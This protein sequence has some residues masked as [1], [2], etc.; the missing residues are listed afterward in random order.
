[1]SSHSFTRALKRSALSLAVGLCFVGASIAAETGGLRV[2]ITG[3]GGAPVAG[4]TIKVS[5]PSSLVSKTGVTAADGTI[6]LSG[7]D[8][9]TNYTV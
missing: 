1:M 9:A 6:F 4:A 2:T 5:S 8:P 3:A 7:L